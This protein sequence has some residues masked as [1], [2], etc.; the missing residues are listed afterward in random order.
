MEWLAN[1]DLLCS[2]RN[3][4]QYSVI[5]YVG[6]EPERGKINEFKRKL[7]GHWVVRVLTQWANQSTVHGMAKL[8]Y[9]DK[10]INKGIQFIH[11]FNF[12]WKL[13]RQ[14]FP[15]W[16]SGNESIRLQVRSLASLSGLRIW[17]CC[18]VGHRRSLDPTWLWC[19]W[20]ATA[21]IRPLVWEPP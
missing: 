12:Y 21:L 11:S 19:R 3:S 20:A 17:R 15:S 13:Y 8:I 6:K 1:R 5:I 7:S 18:G 2:T 14:E 10:F 9:I 16:R 4:T